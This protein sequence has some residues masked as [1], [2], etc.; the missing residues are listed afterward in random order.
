MIEIIRKLNAF[1]DSYVERQKPWELA[2]SDPDQL[3]KVIYNLLEIIRHLAL[4]IYPV[5][6]TVAEK[7]MTNLGQADWLERDF[8]ELID[9]GGLE[10]GTKVTKSEALFPRL[11]K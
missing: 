7:I 4:M 3:V 10:P 8:K 6:P 5:M 11:E 9:W 2:K 1:A